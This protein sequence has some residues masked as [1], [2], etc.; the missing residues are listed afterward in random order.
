MR[1]DHEITV[2]Q[3]ELARAAGVLTRFWQPG[4]PKGE[5]LLSRPDGGG[6]LLE[7]MMA[8]AT[9]P[10]TGRWA[11]E[12]AT[13]A[14]TLARIALRLPPGPVRLLYA[15]SRLVIG[16]TSVPAELVG[17]GPYVP[18][19]SEPAGGGDQF[20]IPGAERISMRAMLERQRAQPLRPRR[21]QRPATTGLFGR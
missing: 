20:V 5:L 12:V 3:A 21:A 16:P 2:D 6:L 10:A 8:E 15:G 14:L 19:D 17:E 7:V 4:E 18:Y 11:G 1:A 9:I 13:C